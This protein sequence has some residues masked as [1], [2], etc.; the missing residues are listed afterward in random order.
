MEVSMAKLEQSLEDQ[1]K[2]L[3]NTVTRIERLEEKA[4][5]VDIR[6]IEQTHQLK[7]LISEAVE[8]GTHKTFAAQ[9]VA[10]AK[11]EGKLDEMKNQYGERLKVLE[12]REAKKELELLKAKDEEKKANRK[13]IRITAISCVITFIITFFLAIILN[14]AVASITAFWAESLNNGAGQA[15][16]IKSGKLYFESFKK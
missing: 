16:F 8:T 13:H 5:A 7:V 10:F 9:E 12:E 14:N 11:L 4:H 3:V 1:N 6:S 15:A 2:M